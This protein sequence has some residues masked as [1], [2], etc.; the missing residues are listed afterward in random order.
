MSQPPLALWPLL[1]DTNRLNEA[2]DLPRYEVCTAEGGGEAG[3]ALDAP[4]TFGPLAR[5]ISGVRGL[6]WDEVPHEWVAGQWWRFDRQFRSG[7][8]LRLMATMGLTQTPT[9][10]ALV[11]FALL[12][13]PNSVVGR[14]LLGSGFL[15]RLGEAFQQRAEDVDA[16]LAG[17]RAT[18]FP[19]ARAPQA[20]QTPEAGAEIDNRAAVMERSPFANGAAPKIASLIATAPEAEIS[21]IRPRRLARILD[22][23]ERKATEACF[24]AAS[25]ELFERCYL[26]LC[27]RCRRPVSEATSLAALPTEGRCPHHDQ[28]FET[29]LAV[30]VELVF[31][32]HP[33]VRRRLS[34]AFCHSGPMTAPHI[35]AQQV[36]EAGEHRVFPYDVSPGA[37]RIRVEPVGS[38]SDRLR[39]ERQFEYNPKAEIGAELPVISV[40]LGRIDFNDA[41]PAGSVV[42]DNRTAMRMRV[43]FERRAWRIDALT[44]AEGA[45]LQA[46]RVLF[47]ADA[48]SASFRAG[49]AAFVAW[50]IPSIPSLFT[51]A[52]DLTAARLLDALWP[53]IAE[54][55]RTAN[56]RLIREGAMAGLA[57]F[58]DPHGAARFE[59]DLR[60]ALAELS[61]D[62]TIS[63]AAA[64]HARIAITGGRTLLTGR[65]Q[66]LDVA[67]RAALLV[68]AL[69]AEAQDGETLLH[70]PLYTPK[71][72]VQYFGVTDPRLEKLPLW[73]EAEP[74][75]VV[76]LARGAAARGSKRPEEEEVVAHAPDGA[77]SPIAAI[78]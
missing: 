62:E 1:A 57:A 73:G 41:A 49:R 8:L 47:G 23:N 51:A 71:A 54:A 30:N 26:L 27:P 43:I 14:T 3:D 16:F 58:L 28:P 69:L 48:P 66:R 22:L 10:G 19:S 44:A 40:G 25:A 45:M 70:A 20:A 63:A 37:Y 4:V 34:G 11:R 68:E 9:G 42:F 36:L 52:P 74:A 76:R 17:R 38:N 18:P 53:R 55:S 24:A 59:R 46:S 60:R 78:R 6:T 35:V 31:R 15:R 64:D 61:A 33:S 7:P 5:S 77:R 72:V 2:L 39:A 65:G 67:G 29:D 32:P 56:G 13:E 75:K 50:S 12:A 21:E